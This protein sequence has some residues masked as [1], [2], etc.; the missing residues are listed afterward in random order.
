MTTTELLSRYRAHRAEG[1]GATTA[2]QWAKSEPAPELDWND[3]GDRAELERDGY[4][5][6]VRVEPDDMVPQDVTFTDNAPDDPIMERLC[7]NP[8]AW[9]NGEP[10][11]GY[12]RRLR[13]IVPDFTSYDEMRR[14]LRSRGYSRNESD[15]RAARSI[16]DLVELF[17]SDDYSVSVVVVEVYRLGVELGSDSLGGIDID[18]RGSWQAARE[19]LESVIAEHDLIGRAVADARETARELCE[20][21]R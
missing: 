6:V 17:A 19:R 9:D 5:V 16:R 2:L 8:N 10:F 12:A 11:S 18:G 14:Y 3:S 20:D 7:R 13:Y 1:I 15:V 21:M 4:H